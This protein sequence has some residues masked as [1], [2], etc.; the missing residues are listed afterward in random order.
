[1]L[2][3]G[4][5]GSVP[6]DGTETVVE[7]RRTGLVIVFPPQAAFGRF[8]HISRT[9]DPVPGRWPRKGLV[10]IEVVQRPRFG[11]HFHAAV[12]SALKTPRF[13][14]WAGLARVFEFVLDGGLHAE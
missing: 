11:N 3:H 1:M 2:N 10:A 13:S 5:R 14:R 7:P 9:N 12:L 4:K 6:S 8:E